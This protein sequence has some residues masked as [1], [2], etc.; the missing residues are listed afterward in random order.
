M[1]RRESLLARSS[2]RAKDDAD[3]PPVTCE[4]DGYCPSTSI[5][6]RENPHS[7]SLLLLLD[8]HGLVMA[9]DE[10]ACFG[11]CLIVPLF[12]PMPVICT[13]MDICVVLRPSGDTLSQGR[14]SAVRRL[15]GFWQV[16][17]RVR[18]T[19]LGWV[20]QPSRGSPIHYYKS[21]PPDT[22]P[23]GNACNSG[24]LQAIRH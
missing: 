14:E 1:Q 7:S 12:R 24:T 16:G 3:L 4:T 6:I 19:P 17:P 11:L 5:S 15:A 20:G 22:K 13:L 2:L 21:M 9:H 10:R 18:T 8:D 23:H